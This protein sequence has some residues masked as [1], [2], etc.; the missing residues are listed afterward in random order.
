ML[1][2][3][4]LRIDVRLFIEG[5]LAILEAIRRVDFNVWRTRPVVSKS[6]KLR[7]LLRAWWQ[8]RRSIKSLNSNRAFQT[9][10]SQELRS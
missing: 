3:P 6:C 1:V 4:A 8:T 9:A 7:L 5:G 2:P 10:A